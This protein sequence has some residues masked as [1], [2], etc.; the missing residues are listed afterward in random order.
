MSLPESH[1]LWL[2]TMDFPW[3]G[4]YHFD[5]DHHRKVLYIHSGNPLK[6]N[7]IMREIPGQDLSDLGVKKWF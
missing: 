5:F 4:N 2:L 6:R 3:W 7:R 1:V